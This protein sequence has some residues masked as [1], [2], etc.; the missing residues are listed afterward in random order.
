MATVPFRHDFGDDELTLLLAAAARV[1]SDAADLP[2]DSIVTWLYEFHNSYPF[3]GIL[4]ALMA[5]DV[6][7]GLCAAGIAQKISSTVSQ[8]GMLRKAVILLLVGVGAVLEPY[9]NG[10]P[11][12]KMIAVGFSV[13]ELISILE[14]T[15]RCGL[16][17]PKP[18]VDMLAK[19]RND[20][21]S[22]TANTDNKTFNVQNASNIEVNMSD[23]SGKFKAAISKTQ[24]VVERTNGNSG[25]KS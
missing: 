12:S 1:R 23:D 7:I 2:V 25:T 14:N 18:L 20:Q 17:V 21:K 22:F 5:A 10:L 13:T 3:V 4:M 9:A 24:P 15:H 16:P 6:L 8:V 11:L 19:L